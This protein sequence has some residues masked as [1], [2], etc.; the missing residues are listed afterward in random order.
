MERNEKKGKE[1]EQRVLNPEI[2]SKTGFFV[3]VYF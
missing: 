3:V 1:R 2:E